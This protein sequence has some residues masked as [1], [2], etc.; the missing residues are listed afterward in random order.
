[1]STLNVPMICCV[2]DLFLHRDFIDELTV[3][4][5]RKSDYSLRG[6][7]PTRHLSIRTERS[8]MAAYT[9]IPKA[10]NYYF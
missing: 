3:K 4:R 1:L 2:Y 5:K 8:K 9:T 6:L 7:E 10:I